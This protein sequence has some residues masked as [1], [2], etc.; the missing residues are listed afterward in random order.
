MLSRSFCCAAT[1]SHPDFYNYILS[2]YTSSKVSWETVC[3]IQVRKHLYN[4]F[5]CFNVVVVKNEGGN[6]EKTWVDSFPGG[7]KS[8]Y[9][10]LLQPRILESAMKNVELPLFFGFSPK[11]SYILLNYRF[12]SCLELPVEIWKI[13]FCIIF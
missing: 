7:K 13:T 3:E 5:F 8:Y 2:P 11:L 9:Y 12:F 10:V 4:I 1:P 6:F